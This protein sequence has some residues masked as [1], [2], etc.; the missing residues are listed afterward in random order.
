M[1]QSKKERAT[2]KR[3]QAE[4]DAKVKKAQREARAKMT[5]PRIKS[6]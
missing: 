2:M 3:R 1:G 4:Q 5:A 6:K